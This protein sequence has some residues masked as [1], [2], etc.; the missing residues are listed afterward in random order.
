MRRARA[1]FQV[2]LRVLGEPQKASAY[3][4][5]VVK[6]GRFSIQ[7]SNFFPTLFVFKSLEKQS[8]KEECI[9]FAMFSLRWQTPVVLR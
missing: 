7:L 1:Q 8:S 3:K 6:T 2:L 4:Y 9:S 5:G